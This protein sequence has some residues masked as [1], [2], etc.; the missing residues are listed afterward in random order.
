MESIFYKMRI[1]QI[2]LY[3]A[4]NSTRLFKKPVDIRQFSIIL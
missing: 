4:Q 2:L 3:M 1:S